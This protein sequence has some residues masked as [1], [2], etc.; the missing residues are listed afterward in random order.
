MRSLSKSGPAVL[1]LALVLTACGANDSDSAACD[2]GILARASHHLGDSN[3]GHRALVAMSEEVLEET[4]GRV[5]IEVFPGAQLGGV[6]EMTSF[7]QSGVVE[8]AWL[9]SSAVSVFLPEAAALNLPFLFSSTDEFHALI[10]GEIGAALNDEI[11]SKVGIEVLY[12]STVGFLYAF[13]AGSEAIVSPDGFSGKSVRVAQSPIF[14]NALRSLGAQPVDLPLGDV[15]SAMQTGAI[16]GFVLPFW[17]AR[18]TS[19]YEVADFAVDVGISHGSKFV[20]VSPSFIDG[21][22]ESDAA[23]IRAAASNAQTLERESWPSEDRD[24][25]AFME[26]NGIEVFTVED[27]ESFQNLVQPFWAEFEATDGGDIWAAIKRDRGLGS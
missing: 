2:S 17:A 18:S 5:K 4:Q 6:A 19:L 24:A 23:A 13:F 27:F 26:A 25:K 1:A 12:W 10:D 15:Y 22:C 11:R 8:F 7:L 21:L 3:A 16:D 20:A 9:D 14:I